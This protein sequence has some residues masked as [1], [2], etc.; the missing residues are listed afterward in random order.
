[1]SSLVTDEKL[2]TLIVIGSLI[3]VLLII[4]LIVLIRQKWW[5]LPSALVYKQL[6][7]SEHKS[8]PL[9]CIRPYCYKMPDF[10]DRIDEWNLGMIIFH[11]E[12]AFTL[13]KYCRFS[14]KIQTCKLTYALS[15]RLVQA[16]S[17][18]LNSINW[19]PTKSENFE[20]LKCSEYFLLRTFQQ[21]GKFQ[22]KIK[23]KPFSVNET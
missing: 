9:I 20:N 14:Q 12:K 16:K 15:F 18:Q 22:K 3:T 11:K 7:D 1:M 10:N 23:I 6:I 5:A 13:Q 2:I 21:Q 4:I 8:P 17:L 19:E